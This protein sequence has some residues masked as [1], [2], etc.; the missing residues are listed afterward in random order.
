MRDIDADLHSKIIKLRLEESIVEPILLSRSIEHAE[1][2]AKIICISNY[3]R[4]LTREHAETA[5]AIVE[6]CFNK[7]KA[8]LLKTGMTRD[9]KRVERLLAIIR[10]EPD[11]TISKSKAAQNGHFSS[12]ELKAIIATLTDRGVI[13]VGTIPGSSAVHLQIVKES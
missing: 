12:Q 9:E 11:M 3:D 10:R 5:Y 6:T 1:K 4:I 2:I 13:K 7:S 8:L